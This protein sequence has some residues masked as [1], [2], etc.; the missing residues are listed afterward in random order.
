M[1]AAFKLRRKSSQLARDLLPN[2]TLE[3]LPLC[4]NDAP[5]GFSLPQDLLASAKAYMIAYR[6]A[7]ILR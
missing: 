7:K 5:W 1:P 2:K 3:A 6:F 4:L